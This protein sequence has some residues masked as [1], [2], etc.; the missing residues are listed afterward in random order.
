MCARTACAASSS[1]S[2]ATCATAWRRRSSRSWRPT[3]RILRL[4]A[5]PVLAEHQLTVH[6]LDSHPVRTEL[7]LEEPDAGPRLPRGD[8]LRRGRGEGALGRKRSVAEMPRDR[9]KRTKVAVLGGGLGAL[10]AAFELTAPE[11]AGHY[12]VTVY[13]PGWRLGGKCASGRGGRAQAN[14]GARAARLVRLLRQLVQHDQ[15]LLRRMGARRERLRSAPGR[16][17][18]SSATTSSC[19]RSGRGGGS[20]GTCTWSPTTRCRA[21]ATTCR[22]GTSC[23]ACSSSCSTSGASCASSTGRPIPPTPE[24]HLPLIGGVLHAIGAGDR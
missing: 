20:R 12:D 16:T 8:G 2:S 4:Q 11:L 24:H 15:A 13:Q 23:S 7:G 17:R 22:H 3:T 9:V 10:A 19:S 5:R 1:S 18:S 14:R 21:R 6:A